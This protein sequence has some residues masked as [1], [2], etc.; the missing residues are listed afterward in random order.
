M[1]PVSK[2]LQLFSCSEKDI[3][4]GQNF[5]TACIIL[6]SGV[7]LRLPFSKRCRKMATAK[8]KIRQ[9]KRRFVMEHL[10]SSSVAKLFGVAYIV[11]GFNG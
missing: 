8:D 11:M 10:Q 3:V 7:R 1:S 9:G 5:S 6:N 2:V 4:R